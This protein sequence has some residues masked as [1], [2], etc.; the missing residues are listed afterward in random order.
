MTRLY[1]VL[2]LGVALA[3]IAISGSARKAPA[4]IK[5]VLVVHTGKIGDDVCTTPLLRAI[6]K[7]APPVRIVVADMGGVS[8]KILANSGLADEFLTIKGLATISSLRKAHLDA[9]ILIVPNFRVL[10]YL[11]LAGI[12]LVSTPRISDGFSPQETRPYTLLARFAATIFIRMHA[13][14]PRERLRLLEPLGISAEDTTKHLGFSEKAR[15]DIEAML[16]EEGIGPHDFFACISVGAGNRIKIWPAD[17]F[18]AV[19]D[20]LWGAWKLPVVLVGARS[21]KEQAEEF[22]SAIS[23]ATRLIDMSERLSLDE[24]KALIARAALF[25]CVDTGPLYIAEAFDIATIDIVGPADEHEQ[26]PIGPRNA[27]V[28]PRGRARAELHVMNARTY[29]AVEARRQVES[30][31]VG[32]VIQAVDGLLGPLGTRI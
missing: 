11:I 16:S 2:L 17:R 3:K 22:L 8:E 19:A 20:H 32:D 13:Y 14:A 23:P 9:A 28:V 24:L 10:A 6:R 7:A 5:S 25:V 30:I 12:P 1:Y 15:R 29:D 18:A 26:P 21:D 27:V 31:T 4:R